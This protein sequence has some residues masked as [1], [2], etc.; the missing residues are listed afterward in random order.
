MRNLFIAFAIVAAATA[1]K[2]DFTG[3]TIKIGVLN[4]QSGLYADLAGPGWPS[5]RWAERSATRPSK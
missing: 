4:D 3:K 1:A 2:A 5:T